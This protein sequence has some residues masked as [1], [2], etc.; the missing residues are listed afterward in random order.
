[1]CRWHSHVDE[2]VTAVV[3]LYVWRD[4]V[5]TAAVHHSMASVWLLVDGY[6]LRCT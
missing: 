5:A 3:L 2:L 1:M 4:D 6:S